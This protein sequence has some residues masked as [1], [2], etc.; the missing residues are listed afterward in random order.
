LLM[1]FQRRFGARVAIARHD[2]F[3]H[4]CEIVSPF[5]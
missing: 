4:F 1:A 3:R 2:D 5:L